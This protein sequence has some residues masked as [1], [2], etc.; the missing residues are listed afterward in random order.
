[1]IETLLAQT[2]GQAFDIAQGVDP[3]PGVPLAL[4]LVAQGDVQRRELC[5]VAQVFQEGRWFMHA[6]RGLLLLGGVRAVVRWLDYLDR[7]RTT[8]GGTVRRF[9][10]LPMAV[11]QLEH[12]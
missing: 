11:D 2:I 10:L 5:P 1:L 4:A 6:H 3:A 9:D 12:L 7:Y 8:V